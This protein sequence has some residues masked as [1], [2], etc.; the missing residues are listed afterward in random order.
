MT[1][2]GIGTRKKIASQYQPSP[3]VFNVAREWKGDGESACWRKMAE[4]CCERKVLNIHE[5]RVVLL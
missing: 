5:A 4:A 1:W 2:G 3:G